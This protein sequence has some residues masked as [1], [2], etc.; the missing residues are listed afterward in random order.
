LWSISA[1]KVVS[2]QTGASFRESLFLYSSSD[3]TFQTL[4]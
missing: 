2:V 4:R 3:L 1:S